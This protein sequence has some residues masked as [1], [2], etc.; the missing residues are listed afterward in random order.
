MD[1]AEQT[2]KSSEPEYVVIASDDPPFRD[3]LFWLIQYLLPHANV[4]T[5]DSLDHALGTARTLAE[6]LRLLLDL[7]LSRDIIWPRLTALCAELNHSKLVVLSKADDKRTVDKVMASGAT[8]FI[9]KSAPPAEMIGSLREI[10]IGTSVERS[11]ARR[12]DHRNG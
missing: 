1:E 9:S 11:R 10:L 2:Q 5:S 8:G 4:L 3:G 12:Q 7:N 6:P